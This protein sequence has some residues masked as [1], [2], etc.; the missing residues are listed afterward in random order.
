M[1]CQAMLQ[2]VTSM[3]MAADYDIYIY[4]YIYICS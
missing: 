4:I 1:R 2:L 3:V